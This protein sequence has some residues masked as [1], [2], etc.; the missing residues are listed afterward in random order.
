[1][2][3]ASGEPHKAGRQRWVSSPPR[4]AFEGPPEK[5][6]VLSRY[7]LSGGLTRRRR[8]ALCIQD[9]PCPEIRRGLRERDCEA[10]VFNGHGRLHLRKAEKMLQAACRRPFRFV[11]LV[12]RFSPLQ[13]AGPS[14]RRVRG[15]SQPL[16]PARSGGQRPATAAKSFPHK[17]RRQGSRVDRARSEARSD[18]G[19]GG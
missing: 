11:C 6:G 13:R 15:A 16:V 4:Q 8:L 19:C 12:T 17:G 5:F 14:G 1:M 7:V 9:A 2:I 10:S 18:Q 3:A